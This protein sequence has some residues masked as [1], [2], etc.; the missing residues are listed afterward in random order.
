MNGNGAGE[1][2]G[3]IDEDFVRAAHPASLLA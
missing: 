2:A 3:E 1:P